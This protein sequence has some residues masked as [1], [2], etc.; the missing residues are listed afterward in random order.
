[1]K[2]GDPCY[3]IGNPAGFDSQ[4]ISS[5]VIRDPAMCDQ[6]QQNVETMY[7]SSSSIGGVSGG[8]ILNNNGNVIGILTYGNNV[9]ETVTNGSS[10]I[11]TV[12][13]GQETLGGGPAEFI[14]QH[15]VKN[16]IDNQQ[17]FLV[18]STHQPYEYPKA[19]INVLFSRISLY[20]VYSNPAIVAMQGPSSNVNMGGLKCNIIEGKSPLQVNDILLSITYVPRTDDPNYALRDGVSG[21]VTIEVG[22]VGDQRA[23]SAATWFMDYTNMDGVE[24][25]VLPF[26]NAQHGTTPTT[27]TAVLLTLKTGVVFTVNG[28]GASSTEFA[29]T[30]NR[31]GTAATLIYG[32]NT[33][34]FGTSGQNYCVGD[35]ITANNFTFTL[36][37]N[38]FNGNFGLMPESN[39]DG[40][41]ADKYLTAVKKIQ[42]E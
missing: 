32:T 11:G 3:I 25:S 19:S 10:Q 4:S 7:V 35:T 6:Y 9:T 36:T 42:Y 14:V 18:N 38:M 33:V 1:M 22:N 17:S 40:T 12:N 26:T 39:E 24:F 30:S 21:K 13:V 37:S 5:G 16:I 8:P 27:R 2:K 31:H 29:T 34:R 28:A 15:V 20:D 41:I 23:V